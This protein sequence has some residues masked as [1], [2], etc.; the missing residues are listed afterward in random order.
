MKYSSLSAVNVTDKQDP[1]FVTDISRLHEHF[2]AHGYKAMGMYLKAVHILCDAF[3]DKKLDPVQR[4]YKVWWAKTFFVCWN[5]NSTYDKQ[6]ITQQTYKDLIC[7]CDGLILYLT[8][9]KKHFP[10]AEVTSYFLGSDQNEQLFAFIR[11]SYSGGRSRNMDA[12]TMAFG[13]ERR[14]VRSLMCS[15][16]D[17]SVIAHTRGRTVLRPAVPADP[18]ATIPAPSKH[19]IPVWTGEMLNL[20]ELARAMNQATNDCIAEGKNYHFPV[21]TA[22]I[23]PAVRFGKPTAQVNEEDDA[24]G[25]DNE[26]EAS[27]ENLLEESDSSTMVTTKIFGKIEFKS[28]ETLL[29]NGGR[30]YLTTKSRLSRFAGDTFGVSSDIRIYSQPECDCIGRIKR[31]SIQTLRTICKAGNNPQVTGVVCYISFKSCPMNFFCLE[32]SLIQGS[33]HIWLLVSDKYL[34]CF[35]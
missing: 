6:S 15:P 21:F 29:L 8:L 28:A 26:I 1:S 25:E 24:G 30:S 3:L 9:L 20:A 34:R 35:I 12:S 27:S 5:E 18:S 4:V 13:M 7:T 2:T 14:N 10:K 23:D 33:P 19:N 16:E 11:T 32:H 31:G 17:T 22:M